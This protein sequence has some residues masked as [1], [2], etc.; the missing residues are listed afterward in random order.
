MTKKET[1]QEVAKFL[2]LEESEASG[3]VEKAIKGGEIKDDA[4]TKW[5]EE[6][7]LPNVVFIDEEGYAK[8]CVDALK[9]LGETAPTD[10][11][12]SRQRDLGHLWADMTRGYLGEL[13]FKMWLEEKNRIEIQLGYEI[14][15]LDEYLAGDIQQVKKEGEFRRPN[16][17]LGIKSTKWNG[18]WLDLP[19]EQFHHSDAHVLIKVGTG[20]DHLFAYF[21]Q[22]SVFK[23]KVLQ[24]GQDIGLLTEEEADGLYESLPGFKPIPA[25]VTGF[26]IRDENYESLSYGGKKGS[27]HFTVTEWDGPIEAGDLDKIKIQENISGNVKFEGIGSFN[28][29]KGYLFNVGNLKWRSE[30]WEFLLESL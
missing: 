3:I 8:M 6:R 11:G 21:K 19:G 17:Q 16:I 15:S 26:A 1:I 7:F 4:Y 14:G 28:H 22:I 13:A 20:R 30:D 27:K 23:D 9:I 12:S 25:Y 10:Y 18:I 2:S 5:F 29:E 24:K